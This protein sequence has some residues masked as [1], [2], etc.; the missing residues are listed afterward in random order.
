MPKVFHTQSSSEYWHRSGSLVHTDPLGKKDAEI[1]SDVR[2]YTFGGTQHGPGNGFP[3]AK[4]GG[5]LP[6]NPANYTPLHAGA[7]RW[8]SMP[9]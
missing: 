9:G 4:A 6:A 3:A 8:R 7:G 5:Q 1:P 2:I